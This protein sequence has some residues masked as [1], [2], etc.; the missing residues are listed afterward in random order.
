MNQ[1][2]ISDA[3]LYTK[4]FKDSI[5]VINIDKE[6][7]DSVREFGATTDINLVSEMGIKLIITYNIDNDNPGYWPSINDK[8]IKIEPNDINAI[9]QAIS[10]QKIP[11]INC[12]TENDNTVDEIVTKIATDI[13]AE[14][15]IFL[16]QYQGIFD[17]EKKLISEI[18]IDKASELLEEN[19][20]KGFI[21]NRLENI[22]LACRQG[23]ERVHII[24]GHLKG[25]LIQELFTSDGIGTMVYSHAPYQTFR[26]AI[27]TDTISIFLLIKE[28]I[29]HIFR[30]FKD[31]ESK[32]D[33]FFLLTVDDTIHACLKIKHHEDKNAL[34]I[35]HLCTSEDYNNCKTYEKMFNFIF[36]YAQEKN[37][38]YIYLDPNRN[39]RWPW[40]FPKILIF[41]KNK[42]LSI[43]TQ[44]K[45]DLRPEIKILAS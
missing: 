23:V 15:I 34:E 11:F 29:P 18:D 19:F 26:Q 45:L 28:A 32:I 36:D 43:Q 14:K 6:V 12:Y 33:K 8:L 21:K 3:L 1:K 16:S 5:F 44:K 40:I 22:I 17:D 37:I 13:N 42:S 7:I 20:I 4:K 9:L 38:Q 24:S 2:A 30:T 41:E 31:I 10:E 25:A 39:S 27:G 35:S